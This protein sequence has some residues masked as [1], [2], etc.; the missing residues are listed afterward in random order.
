MPAEGGAFGDML[1]RAREAQGIDLGA[2]ARRT[3]IAPHHLEA[4]ERSDLDALPAGPFGRSY[5]RA[6]AEA[7][8]IEPEPILEAYRVHE[9]R[10]GLGTPEGERRMLQELSQLAGRGAEAGRHPARVPA[11]LVVVVVSVGILATVGWLLARNRAA[12]ETSAEAPPQ[13]TPVPSPLVAAAPRARSSEPPAAAGRGGARHDR[14]AADAPSVSPPTDPLQVSGFGVG[15]GVVDRR[16]VGRADRLPEGS[17]VVFWTEVRG[18]RPGH[19]IRHVWFHE[20][21]AVMKANLAI[22]GPHWRTHSTLVLP[23]GSAGR[24]TVEARTS[25]GR[26]LARNDFVCEPLDARRPGS[27]GE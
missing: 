24:W 26:L 7:L 21:R 17:R 6:Y 3:R 20:G 27:T 16:L 13:P 19:V 15:T 4:L 12:R 14:P 11:R 9:H 5:V 8:G 23:R 18:G 25:D 1:R 22:R 2:V 10:R